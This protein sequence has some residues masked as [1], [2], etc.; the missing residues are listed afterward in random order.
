M[1]YDLQYT[2]RNPAL[3]VEV[4]LV[5]RGLFTNYCTAPGGQYH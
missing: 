1:T 5:L 3:T 4:L 2:C